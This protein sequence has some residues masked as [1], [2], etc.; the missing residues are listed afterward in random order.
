MGVKLGAKLQRKLSKY[1]VFCTKFLAC[2]VETLIKMIAKGSDL[3]E[4][5][6]ALKLGKM[7]YV[8]IFS[9]CLGVRYFLN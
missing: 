2:A 4:V 9:C 7:K 1:T 6:D 3:D 8:N 5:T